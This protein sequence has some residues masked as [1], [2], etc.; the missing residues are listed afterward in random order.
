M[1]NSVRFLAIRQCILHE[2][3][4]LAFR[5]FAL[6]SAQLDFGCNILIHEVFMIEFS[7]VSFFMVIL[8]FALYFRIRQKNEQKLHGNQNRIKPM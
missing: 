4:I 8:N 2:R 7:I 1:Q 6:C 5:C 3:T